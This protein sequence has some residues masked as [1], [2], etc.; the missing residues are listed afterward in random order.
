MPRPAFTGANHGNGI[1][2]PGIL[3]EGGGPLP[4][5][6]SIKF[7]TAGIYEFE[8]VIPPEMDAKIVV[9]K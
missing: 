4:S 3:S 2:G 5:S 9:R 7:T 1:E 8:C 6:A